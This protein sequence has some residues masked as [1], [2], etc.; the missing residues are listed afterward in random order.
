MSRRSTVGPL[1]IGIVLMLL[2]LTLA[3]GFNLLNEWL[4]DIA[5]TD[6]MGGGKYNLLRNR[7]FFAASV[8]YSF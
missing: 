4:V 8:R 5:Y 1:T 6:Y 7:D 3:V 2:L